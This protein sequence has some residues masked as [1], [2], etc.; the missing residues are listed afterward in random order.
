M[1]NSCYT[2]TM[3]VTVDTGGTKTLIAHF[4]HD[5]SMGESVKFPTP[6]DPAA[7]VELVR[8][9]LQE[10]YGDKK[11]DA[12][13]IAIPGIIK[14]GVALWCKNLGWRNFH[15]ADAFHGVLGTVP[16]F[17]ENDAKLA[18]LAE[19]RVLRPMPLSSLYVTIST[20]IG[21]G[22]IV[23][24]SI[25]PGFRLSEGG[26]M[27]L[28]YDGVIQ[29]WEHFASG[30]AIVEV[31][32][33][34][35]RDITSKRTWQQIADRLSRGFLAIIPLLQPEIII[36]GGSVGLYYDKYADLLTGILREK[37]PPHIP[38]PVFHQAK[39]PETAVLY[40]CYY[41]ALDQLARP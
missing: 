1:R 16:I 35:A 21:T 29:Q 25:D 18:G 15:A 39:H 13:V 17:I 7:Y 8:S 37:L 40:G 41:Y 33:K 32:G 3:L 22:M 12:I 26:Q 23:D 24:G 6:R 10:R 19:T 38:C 5:G 14:D 27:L 9:T 36:I 30:H 11:V 20:G 31:Y 34:Y 2:T 4:T 28:E